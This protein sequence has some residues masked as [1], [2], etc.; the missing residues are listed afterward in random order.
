MAHGHH[1]GNLKLH[2]KYVATQ[3]EVYWYN[4]LHDNDVGE[5]QPAGIPTMH[6]AGD[7]IIDCDR[8]HYIVMQRL[9]KN[10]EVLIKE[11]VINRGNFKKVRHGEFWFL[12]A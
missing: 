5:P 8:H 9:G 11:K 12:I 4:Y 1:D 3:E 7:F 10:L 2:S 6:C